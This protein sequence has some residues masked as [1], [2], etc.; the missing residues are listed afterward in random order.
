MS[1]RHYS[2]AHILQEPL[3]GYFAAEPLLF[4]LLIHGRCNTFEWAPI[5][6]TFRKKLV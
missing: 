4:R 2:V 6:P 5:A 1:R 3:G